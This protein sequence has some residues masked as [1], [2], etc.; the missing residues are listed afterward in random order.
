MI[1]VIVKEKR[2]SLKIRSV[3]TSSCSE[4][5][6]STVDNMYNSGTNAMKGV[7]TNQT[8]IL[9]NLLL[10]GTALFSNIANCFFH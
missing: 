10:K 8:G 9:L 6:K 3:S 7:A 2:N 5:P 4:P 1:T